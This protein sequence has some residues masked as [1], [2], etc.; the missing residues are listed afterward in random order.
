M[1]V[2]KFVLLWALFAIS[3]I[4]FFV[5]VFALFPEREVYFFIRERYDIFIEENVWDNWFMSIVLLLS[6]VINIVFMF[7]SLAITQRLRRRNNL[8]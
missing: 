5:L 7:L 2:S 4:V 8:P 3:Y 6:L 1:K